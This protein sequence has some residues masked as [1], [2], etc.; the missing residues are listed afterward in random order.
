MRSI[1]AIAPTTTFTYNLQ[2]PIEP[3]MMQHKSRFVPGDRLITLA[4]LSIS[5]LAAFAVRTIWPYENVFV[6]GVVWFRGMDAWYHMRLVDS[7]VHNFPFVTAFDPFTFFPRGVLAI[8]H[9]LTNWLIAV[10]ALIAGGGNPSPE[11]VDICGAYFPPVLGALTV[12]PVYFIGRH[13]FGPIAGAV[14]ALLIAV[15]PGEFLSRSLLGFADHHVT[16]TFFST[17]ALLFLMIAT[18]QASVDGVTLHRPADILNPAYRRTLLYTGLAGLALGLYILAWRG[19]VLILGILFLYVVVRTLIDYSTGARGNDLMLVCSGATAIAVVIASPTV[20]THYM[21]VLYLLA[22]IGVVAAPFGSRLFSDLGRRLHWSFRTFVLVAI[23]G[24]TVLL[25]FIAIAIPSLWHNISGAVAFMVPTG[26]HL[27]IMEMHPLFFP[28][29]EFS[30]AVAWW[31]NFTTALGG[32]ILGLFLLVRS[33]RTRRGNSVVLFAVWSFVMLFAVLL[34]RRFGY[35]YAVNAAV[36]CGFLTAWV[37]HSPWMEQ[38]YQALRQRAPVPTTLKTQSKKARR[39]IESHRAER[40]AAVFSI[41]TVAII[42]AGVLFVPNVDMA[43]NFAKEPSLMTRGWWETLGWMR[44][45]T[46]EPLGPD[47]YYALYDPQTEHGGFEYPPE[48]YGV[49]AWWDYGHWITRV[50][51]RIPVA[52]PF[53]QGARQAGLFLTTQSEAEGALLMDEYGCRYV[54]IDSR[55]SIR[56]FHDVVAWAQLDLDDYREVYLQRTPAGTLGRV[57]LYYPEYYR[58]MMVRLYNFGG[59]AFEPEEYTAIRYEERREDGAIL[60]EIIDMREF[61]TYDEARAFIDSADDNRWRLVGTNPPVSA[62]PL[63]GLQQF[64]PVFESEAQTFIQAQLLPEVRVFQY[65]G[66]AQ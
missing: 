54:V 58:S 23:G 30:F 2:D 63:S 61:A 55:T 3:I 20:Q 66:V 48:A 29:G 44:E 9:P 13:L 35:Y 19:S 49:M 60:K 52:N 27:T 50:S 6:D 57:V 51:Q 5:M 4:I 12:I 37:F 47:G 42:V 33:A 8:F 64:S 21:S 15:L 14:S 17:A 24:F 34:Q 1:C 16:E 40:R 43:R 7:L 39:A 65:T 10:P 31:N 41:V 62:V 59:E 53:Q 11:L 56:T 45:N 28:G 22:M 32:S 46:P 36:L 38:Q 25:V 18:R 26:A